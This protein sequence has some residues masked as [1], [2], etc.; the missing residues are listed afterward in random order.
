MGEHPYQPYR[1]RPGHPP[2]AYPPPAPPP[3]PAAYPRQP[4]HPPNRQEPTYLPPLP[5]PGPPAPPAPPAR[6][7]RR[8]RRFWYIIAVAVLLPAWLGF[9]VWRGSD[10]PYGK[11]TYDIGTVADRGSAAEVA[12]TAWRLSSIGPVPPATDS[13]TEPPPRDAQLVRAY[14]EVTPHTAAA[15]KKIIVCE[16]AAQ[17]DRSRVWEPADS[18]Y[19]SSDDTVPDNCSPPGFGAE[20]IPAGHTQKVGVT[21]L[22]PREAARSLRPMVRPTSETQYVLFR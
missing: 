2:P 5:P 11:G 22:V 21:F 8:P 12:G 9:L 14:I 19:V 3:P 16:F 1:P 7:H 15:A 10:Q 6:P 18:A 13:L 17:D 20:Y 4:V